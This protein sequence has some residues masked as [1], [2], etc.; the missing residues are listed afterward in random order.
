MTFQRRQICQSNMKDRSHAEVSH[1]KHREMSSALLGD[2]RLGTVYSD[3]SA[4]DDNS[5]RNHTR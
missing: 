4:N 3:T 5:F 1:R 2:M